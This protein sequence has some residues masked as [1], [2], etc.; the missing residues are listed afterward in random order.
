[1]PGRFNQLGLM[2]IECPDPGL[3]CSG[4]GTGGGG[5][6]WFDVDRTPISSPIITGPVTTSPPVEPIILSPPVPINSPVSTSTPAPSTNSTSTAVE[7][8]IA[9][10]PMS[11]LILV[12]GVGLGAYVLLK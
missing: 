1:M 9:E 7:Q 2:S 10:I 4:G 11:T 12:L 3:G 5:G 6:G 8:T